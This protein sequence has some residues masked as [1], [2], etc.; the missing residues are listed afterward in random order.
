MALVSLFFP[1]S[2]TPVQ[3]VDKSRPEPL[4]YALFDE[5]AAVLAWL[6]IFVSSPSC[7]PILRF[8]SVYLRRID[9]CPL[10]Y[11]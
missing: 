9:V 7:A 5:T 8:I 1:S 6:V 10:C 11:L 3:S 2:S 4:D